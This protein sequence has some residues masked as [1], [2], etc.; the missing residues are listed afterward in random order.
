LKAPT[1][2]RLRPRRVA[3]VTLITGEIGTKQRQG[4]H[5]L[6]FEFPATKRIKF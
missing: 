6:Q 1:T 5:A 4:Q 2:R 3:A